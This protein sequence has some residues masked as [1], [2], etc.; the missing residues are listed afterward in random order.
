[1]NN[2]ETDEMLKIRFMSISKQELGRTLKRFKGVGWDQSPIF[3]KNL[4]AGVRSVRRRAVCCIV[5]D[6]YFDHSPQD[7]E[8]LGKWR[9]SALRRTVRLSPVPHRA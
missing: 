3:K 5:G 8:L 4:R 1:M 7:V 6:Y 2:T 9:A